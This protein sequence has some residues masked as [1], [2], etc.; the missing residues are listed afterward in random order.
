ML[1]IKILWEEIEQIIVTL[2]QFIKNND[3]I[4]GGALIYCIIVFMLIIKAK[5]KYVET[6]L[7]N[8]KKRDYEDLKV[9][10]ERIIP[11]YL[12]DI[13]GM[14]LLIKAEHNLYNLRI[15]NNVKWKNSRVI[16]RKECVNVLKDILTSK[17]CFL[18]EAE[19]AEGYPTQVMVFENETYMRC[20]IPL[21]YN[22]KYGDISIIGKYKLTWKSWI[23]FFL[24]G[25][26]EYKR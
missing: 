26:V 25:I 23:Y 18:L 13:S 5:R 15:Y 20:E 24:F 10:E 11:E 1:R 4:V 19:T 6:F 2:I 16:K 14:K 7:W 12:G 9:Y 22:G 8:P 21:G 17:E 3:V